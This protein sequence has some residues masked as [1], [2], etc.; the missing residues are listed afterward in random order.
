MFVVEGIRLGFDGVLGVILPIKVVMYV[1]RWLMKCCWFGM[2][3]IFGFFTDALHKDCC[4]SSGG[5]KWDADDFFFGNRCGNMPIR[6][7]GMIL[8]FGSRTFSEMI[9]R[10][11]YHYRSYYSIIYLRSYVYI[12]LS[13]SGIITPWLISTL[14]TLIKYGCMK[15]K[16][17]LQYI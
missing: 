13:F 2:F 7:Q 4:L 17:R 1:F 9:S 11:E 5:R 12:F 8:N 15:Y 16:F 14:R 10:E 3:F 6:N